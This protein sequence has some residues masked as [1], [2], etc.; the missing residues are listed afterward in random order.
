LSSLLLRS[1]SV[2]RDHSTVG[3]LPILSRHVAQAGIIA[4]AGPFRE[5][6]AV[7]HTTDQESPDQ[8][9]PT[10]TAMMRDGFMVLCPPSVCCRFNVD[11]R[12]L[13]SYLVILS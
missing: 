6:R 12:S 10:R 7:S 11:P 1:H 4:S 5:F 9:D 8:H 2:A 3:L 13:Y